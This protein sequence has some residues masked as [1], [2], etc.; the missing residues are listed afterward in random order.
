MKT[1]PGL[2]VFIWETVNYS[3]KSSELIY[4]TD[5]MAAMRP[6]LMA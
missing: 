2:V 3:T 4:L 5:S 6:E 1:A